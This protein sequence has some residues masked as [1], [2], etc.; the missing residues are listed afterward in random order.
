MAVFQFWDTF[1]ALFLFLASPNIPLTFDFT[2]SSSSIKNILDHSFRINKRLTQPIVVIVQTTI[3]NIEKKKLR[4]WRGFFTTNLFQIPRIIQ[5]WDY[6]L[7]RAL[8]L[9]LNGIPRNEDIAGDGWAGGLVCIDCGRTSLSRNLFCQGKAC[10]ANSARH[11]TDSWTDREKQIEVF[12]LKTNF[13]PTCLNLVCIMARPFLSCQ[14][15]ST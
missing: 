5:L 12:L 14:L 2:H 6:K 10:N 8:C 9:S 7:Q 4:K 1:R 3:L 11:K 13:D 15:F